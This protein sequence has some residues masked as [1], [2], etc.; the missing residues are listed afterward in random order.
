MLV[1]RG[2]VKNYVVAGQ[3][4]PALRGIDLSFRNNEFVSILGPSGCGKTTMMNIIGG[5][6]RYT[7][8]DLIVDGKSTKNFTESEWDSYRNATIGFVFQTYNLISHL[9]VLDNVEMSLRLSGVGQKERRKR[10]LDVLVEVGLKDHVHKRPNQLSGGQ[11]QRV[12]IA[13]ALVNNPKILLADEPTGAL[14]TITSGQILELIKKISKGRLVIMVTHNAELASAHSDRIVRLLDGRVVDDSRPEVIDTES[15]GKLMTKRTTMPFSTALKTS[16]NNLLT[17]KGR[18]IITSLAGS[19]GIIGIALVLS[20][21]QGMNIYVGAL[22]SDT[23]AGFPITITPSI[24]QFGPPD[25][26]NPSDL[27][28]PTTTVITGYNS[29]PPEHRNNINDEFISYVEEMPS[30]Y[31]NA[32]TYSRAMAMRLISKTSSDGYNIVSSAALGGNPFAFVR[33]FY[34]MPSNEQFILSQYDVL[35]GTYPSSDQKDQLVLVVDIRNRID[36][37]FFSRYGIDVT[38]GIDFNE[39]VGPNSIFNLRWI[40]N[41]QLFYRDDIGDRIRYQ[42]SN[43][44]E[45]MYEASTLPL[46]IAAVIRVKPS[47]SAQLLTPGLAYSKALTTFAYEDETVGALSSDIVISQKEVWADTS[48]PAYK[49][50]G[51][52]LTEFVSEEAY[53]N[54]LKE[55]GGLTTPVGVQIYPSSFDNKDAIKRYIDAYNYDEDGIR[56]PIEEVIIYTDLA[57]NITSTITELINTITI[58]LTAFASISLFVSSIM[59]GIITYVSVIERTKEIG[60]MRSLGARKK[61]IARIF[62]AETIIIGFVSG[63]FGILITLVLNIPID[64]VIFNLIDVENFTSL[65]PIYAFGLIFLSTFLTLLAGLIPSGIA[66]RKDPVIALRTE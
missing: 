43:D 8:G 20:I 44:Y 56:R 12:A 27:D 7:E 52:S 23:L 57:E 37:G 28:Y 40:S 58:V 26:A 41:N 51:S 17:K 59:I 3:P 31:Y 42:I 1:L 39:I 14:D 21:S 36:E 32:I 53:L 16:A 65:S 35:A 15:S 11:M 18:T 54:E 4:F 60:I 47:A 49:I 10:A 2:I 62:N 24:R 64:I 34:E 19:I 6:D 33:N 55:L 25:I 63:V 66:A 50:L 9:S 48:R 5:L 29:A 22:Q 61:D 38:G 46:Q 13:R 30:D 45:T